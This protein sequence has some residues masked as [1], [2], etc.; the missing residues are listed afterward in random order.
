MQNHNLSQNV[1]FEKDPFCTSA[2][3]DAAHKPYRIINMYGE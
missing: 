1:Y 3:H 2:D